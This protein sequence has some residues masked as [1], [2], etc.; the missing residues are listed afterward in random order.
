MPGL[1]LWEKA[2][3]PKL[4]TLRE[5]DVYGSIEFHEFS[6]SKI[7]VE[8]M[9]RPDFE[10][11]GQSAADMLRLSTEAEHPRTRERCLALYMI[12]TNQTNATRWAKEIDRQNMT[13]H[14]WVHRYNEQGMAGII[15]AHTG[16]PV[17]FL[18]GRSAKRSPRQ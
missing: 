2:T 13:V 16:G 18:P 15:Y 4:K 14:G 12:G 1:F 6:R 3:A 11:W 7:E 10:K 5:H 17:P 8:T 9:L